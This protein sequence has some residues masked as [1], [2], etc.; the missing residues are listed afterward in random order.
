M[1]RL[2]YVM[3]AMGLAAALAGP[4]QAQDPPACSHGNLLSDRP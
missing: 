4:G 1:I 3:L 2:S